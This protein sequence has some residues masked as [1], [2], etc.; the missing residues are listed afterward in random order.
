[1]KSFLVFMMIAT[2][3]FGQ[4][5]L[6]DKQ[7]TTAVLDCGGYLHPGE[8]T[9]LEAAQVKS[10]V[11]K[12]LKERNQFENLQETVEFWEPLVTM[13]GNESR[14]RCRHHKGKRGMHGEDSGEYEACLSQRDCV[15][16]AQADHVGLSDAPCVSRNSLGVNQ[17]RN[18][19]SG[20]RDSGDKK[21]LEF[22]TPTKP[23]VSASKK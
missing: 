4:V 23:G 17:D 19:L 2:S 12:K 10:C 20:D 14:L 11:E 21:K 8:A 3:A 1:M 13:K 5:K 16:P 6:S 7:F 15:N 18:V 22:K 9:E